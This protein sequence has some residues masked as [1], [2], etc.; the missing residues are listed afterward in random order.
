MKNVEFPY[1]YAWDRMMGSGAYWSTQVQADL[2]RMNAPRDAIY[3]RSGVGQD[4]SVARYSEIQSF[5]TKHR[6]W[7]LVGDL[8]PDF[9]RGPEPK[10]EDFPKKIVVTVT[11][12][13]GGTVHEIYSCDVTG[14]DLSK[15]L[16]RASLISEIASEVE[17]EKL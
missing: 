17:K 10:L 5:D 11:T 14:Y 3:I 7:K 12:Y 1:A 9:D 2:K 6:V 4:G 13:Q 15:P 8:F 16:A